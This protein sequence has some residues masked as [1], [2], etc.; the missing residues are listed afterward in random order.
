MNEQ[1]T[2]IEIKQNPDKPIAAEIIAQSIVKI[3]DAMKAMSSTRLRRCAIV[4]LIHEDTKI[5]RRDIE[6]VLSSLDTLEN[7]WLKP[8]P[9]TPTKTK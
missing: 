2:V 3:G 8:A 4:T 9:I 5:A 1:T 7:Q 6:K